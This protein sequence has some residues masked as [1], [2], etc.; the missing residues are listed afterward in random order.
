MCIAYAIWIVVQALSQDLHKN[1]VVVTI[2]CVVLLS[3]I[4]DLRSS[5]SLI[6]AHSVGQSGVTKSGVTGRITLPYGAY[7]TFRAMSVFPC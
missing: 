4:I 3:G 1:D 7:K 5:T 6:V 2:E